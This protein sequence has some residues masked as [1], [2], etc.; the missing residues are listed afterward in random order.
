MLFYHPWRP[1]T[2]HP[3]PA[4]PAGFCYHL[5]HARYEHHIV[6]ASV[7]KRLTTGY[8]AR[9]PRSTST[10]SLQG[11][12][13]T[14]LRRKVRKGESFI[15]ERSSEKAVWGGVSECMHPHPR[16]ISGG[17]SATVG[18]TPFSWAGKVRRDWP[19]IPGY[20]ADVFGLHKLCGVQHTGRAVHLVGVEY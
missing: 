18:C 16:C 9:H 14:Q 11:R 8:T 10:Y 13:S 15:K 3:A 12:V 6:V 20:S 5:Q 1:H 17:Y 2:N 19:A 7:Y 4:P